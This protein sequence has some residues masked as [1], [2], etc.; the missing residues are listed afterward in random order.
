MSKRL[1]EEFYDYYLVSD[2]FEADTIEEAVARL[3]EDQYEDSK[4]SFVKVPIRILALLQQRFKSDLS[5]ETLS[6]LYVSAILN[7]QAK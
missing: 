2:R 3:A 5:I 7:K 4:S 1:D 6:Q